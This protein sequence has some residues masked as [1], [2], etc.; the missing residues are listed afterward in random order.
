MYSS[1][2]AEP[3]LVPGIFEVMLGDTL[4][5]GKILTFDQF[6]HFTLSFV[7]VTFCVSI[8]F[9]GWNMTVPA[10]MLYIFGSGFVLP[11]QH[12]PLLCIALDHWSEE[13]KVDISVNFP[14]VLLIEKDTSCLYF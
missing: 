5:L 13:H 14:H 8:R 4:Q 12:V 10:Q 11:T 6:F 2:V 1:F 3:Y 9:V 7:L